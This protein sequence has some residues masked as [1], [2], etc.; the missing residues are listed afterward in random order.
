MAYALC[1]VLTAGA[2]EPLRH[3]TVA[4]QAALFAEP[5]QRRVDR[6]DEP[7]RT[8]SGYGSRSRAHE[9]RAGGDYYRLYG[10]KIFITWADHDMTD[11]VIILVL[12][13][14]CRCA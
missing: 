1:P 8:A 7:D 10:Q 9:G 14:R 12:R 4:T 5:R 13:A 11:N 2:T 3:G 6:H